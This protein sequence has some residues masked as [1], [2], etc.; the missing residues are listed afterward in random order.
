MPAFLGVEVGV[1]GQKRLIVNEVAAD[2]PAAKAGLQRGDRLLKVDG[3]E[4]KDEGAFREMLRQKTKLPLAVGFGIGRAEQIEALRSLADGVIVGS[5]IVRQV[6]RL[7]SGEAPRKAVM[8]DLA[9]FTR[10]LTAAAHKE[11]SGA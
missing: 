8:E 6:G 1:D 9:R 3:A 10:E 2:S 5:A 11:R 7:S 4:P